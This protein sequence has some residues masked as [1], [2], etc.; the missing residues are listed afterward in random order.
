M[1][2]DAVSA[3]GIDFSA[4]RARFDQ[5][6]ADKSGGLSLEEFEQAASS[7]VI[8]EA[9]SADQADAAETFASFDADGDGEVTSTEAFTAFSGN[10]SS[11]AFM[12]LLAAQ[13]SAT[14]SGIDMSA[15]RSQLTAT[16]GSQ[17]GSESDVLGDLLDSLDDDSEEE[18]AA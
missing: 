10:F 4:M 2:F 12:S 15:A 3:F 5:A 16:Y 11:D 17:E 9:G 1:S 6:D 13:E 7:G 8:G 18:E 14:A